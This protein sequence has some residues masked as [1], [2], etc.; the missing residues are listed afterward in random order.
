MVDENEQVVVETDPISQEQAALDAEQGGA[1]AAPTA[2]QMA[3]LAKK[4]DLQAVEVT[5]LRNENRGLQGKIDSGLT[6]IRRDTKTQAEERIRTAE[7][8]SRESYLEKIAKTDPELAEATRLY[9]K[10]Q[11]EALKQRAELAAEPESVPDPP[12]QSSPA[13]D[14]GALR[15]WVVQMGGNPD[16][17]I[18]YAAAV[19]PAVPQAE[20][21]TTFMKQVIASKTETPAKAAPPKDTNSPP[22]AG[23]ASA[24]KGFNNFD[25]YV[26]AYLNGDIDRQKYIEGAERFHVNV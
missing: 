5:T 1:A 18:D 9:H 26:N 12:A 22:P 13:E 3:D 10:G 11:D 19:N 2:E 16:T 7:L 14:E 6:A 21:Q 25:D 15:A 4:I 23:G 20:R 8:Q 17:G 24:G